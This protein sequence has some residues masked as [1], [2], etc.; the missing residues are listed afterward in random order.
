MLKNQRKISQLYLK[1]IKENYPLNTPLFSLNATDKDVGA[2]PHLSYS[3]KYDE[4]EYFNFE[5]INDMCV[6]PTRVF[7]A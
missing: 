1:R 6:T 5:E 2:N 4:G 7:L 3:I